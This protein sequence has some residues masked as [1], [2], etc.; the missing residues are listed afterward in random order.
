MTNLLSQFL[1][2]EPEDFASLYIYCAGKYNLRLYSESSKLRELSCSQIIST[3]IHWETY[4]L[5]IENFYR[6]NE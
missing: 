5:I 1:N 2:K 4:R 3:V 6:K